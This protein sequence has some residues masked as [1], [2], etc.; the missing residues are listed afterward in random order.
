VIHGDPGRFILA[1]PDPTD[2]SEEAIASLARIDSAASQ[3]TKAPLPADG[4]PPLFGASMAWTGEALVAWGGY[5]EVPDPEGDDG[6]EPPSP[7]PCD[8]ATPTK[9]VYE[10]TGLMIVPA[11]AP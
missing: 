2:L 5:L 3:W 9:R 8:P 1:V 10:R 7:N 6:C 11:F 4:R